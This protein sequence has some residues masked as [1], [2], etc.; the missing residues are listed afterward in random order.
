MNIC[1][2]EHVPAVRT[3]DA[4]TF[5]TVMLFTNKD[6]SYP[7]PNRALDKL[8]SIRID[9]IFRVVVIIHNS[10]ARMLRI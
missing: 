9:P 6:F 4:F 2:Q 1:A 10:A 7:S 8:P 5:P 3:V